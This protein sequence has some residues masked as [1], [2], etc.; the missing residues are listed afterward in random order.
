[1][2]AIA[3]SSSQILLS[4]LKFLASIM[5]LMCDLKFLECIDSLGLIIDF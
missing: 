3:T 2:L 4:Q 5:D 1:M